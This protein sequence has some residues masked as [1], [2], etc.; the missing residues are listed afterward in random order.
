[1]LAMMMVTMVM[2]MVVRV[3]WLCVG[4]DDDDDVMMMMMIHLRGGHNNAEL[5]LQ[6]GWLC[7][8]SQSPLT[9]Q[10]QLATGT[11]VPSPSQS[12]PT[13][14]PRTLVDSLLA[15]EQDDNQSGVGWFCYAFAALSF[16][17]LTV[18]PDPLS[19]RPRDIA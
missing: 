6:C 18:H 7:V 2:V 14:L 9:L 1:M 3:D 10:I 19:R 16:G 13:F 4:D 15:F 8:A 17:A 11:C 12:P 5:R